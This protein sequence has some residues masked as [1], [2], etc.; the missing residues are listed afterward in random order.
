MENTVSLHPEARTHFDREAEA[1]VA[2]LQLLPTLGQSLPPQGSMAHVPIVDHITDADIVG[3]VT[4]TRI[5]W[6]GR[7]RGLEVH[8]TDI[9]ECL[10]EQAARK[11][12]QIADTVASRR[13]LR[14]HCGTPYIVRHLSDWVR[15]RRVSEPA[16]SSWTGDLL[17]NLA[18]DVTE[19][20]ILIPLEGIHITAPFRLGQVSFDYFTEAS[21]DEM[22]HSVPQDNL[23]IRNDWKRNYQGRVYARYQC[24]AESIQ[25]AELAI[26]H[27]DKAL[28]I[29]L[30]AHLAAGDIRARSLIGRM[31]QVAPAER[32]VFQMRPSGGPLLSRGGEPSAIMQFTVDA[33]H[34]FIMRH[35][36][37]GMADQLLRKSQP[38]DLE[39]KALEAISHFAHGV[40]SP[41]RQDRLIHAVV[42]V[43]SLLLKND[44][45]PIEANLGPRIAI[46]TASTLPDR[47]QAVK[48]FRE[49]YQLRSKFLHHGAKLNEIDTANR[50]LLLCLSAVDAVMM[51]TPKFTTKEALLNHLDDERLAPR[52]APRTEA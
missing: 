51:M 33:Q 39:E 10:P 6:L 37:I 18:R 14:E 52:E 22:L 7:F 44:N 49:G 29:L 47:K 43:E 50:L 17:A 48:D 16:D 32:H 1:L 26:Y 28:E 45:E 41:A 3:P 13:E 8:G 40:A 42:A 23:Q 46:L 15:R 21:I 5:D 34:L 20:T 31:G 25:A 30:L 36:G 35:S 11:L 9:H 24:T 19:R 27:T 4:L 2:A 12:E 38:T